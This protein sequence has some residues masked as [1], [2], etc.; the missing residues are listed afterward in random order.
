M[1][2][3]DLKKRKKVTN[4]VEIEMK[5]KFKLPRLLSC[6]LKKKKKVAIVI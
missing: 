3:F 6:C 5:G 2:R 4:L 1:V